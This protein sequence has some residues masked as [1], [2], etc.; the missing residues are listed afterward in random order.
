MPLAPY[1]EADSPVH[2][3]ANRSE[4]RKSPADS[5]VRQH[6]SLQKEGNR[7]AC[8]VLRRGSGVQRAL[9]LQIGNCSCAFVSD[10]FPEL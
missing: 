2:A 7:E 10:L 3:P 9:S 1:A 6:S 5:A 8:R 4:Q